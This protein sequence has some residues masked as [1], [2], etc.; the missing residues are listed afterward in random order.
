VKGT[1]RKYTN[2]PAGSNCSPS[3]A[4]HEGGQDVL[5]AA[6]AELTS[7]SSSSSDSIVSTMECQSSADTVASGAKS[8]YANTP[9]SAKTIDEKMIVFHQSPPIA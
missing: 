7:S 3:S 8:Q 9:S 1:S 4:Q 2:E 5:M 6:A